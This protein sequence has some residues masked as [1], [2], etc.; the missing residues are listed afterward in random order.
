MV[1]YGSYAYAFRELANIFTGSRTIRAKKEAGRR[2]INLLVGLSVGTAM[3]VTAG[4]LSAPRSG[5]ET[6]EKLASRTS[7][8]VGNLKE[9]TAEAKKE[10]EKE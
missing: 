5:R 9:K 7:E 1:R 3:G 6:R 8:I 4:I 10:T 2:K